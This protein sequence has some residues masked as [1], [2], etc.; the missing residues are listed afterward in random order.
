MIICVVGTTSSGYT[1]LFL[2]ISIYTYGQYCMSKLADYKKRKRFEVYGCIPC[3]KTKG[4][5][6]DAHKK[7]MFSL[8]DQTFS[9]RRL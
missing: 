4:L 8:R 3:L 2:V 6:L 1:M 5:A 9:N 7:E